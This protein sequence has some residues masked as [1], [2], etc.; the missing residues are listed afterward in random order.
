MAN[1]PKYKI[2]GRTYDKHRVNMERHIGRK[3]T[4]YEVVHHVNGDILDHR[5]ENLEILPLAVH[6]RLHQSGSGNSSA[7]LNNIQVV[8]IREALVTGETIASIARRYGLYRATIQDIK[9]RRT[10]RDL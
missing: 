4:R 6:S 8:A 3:L 9:H 2:H 5:I 1:Y 10:W 7:K